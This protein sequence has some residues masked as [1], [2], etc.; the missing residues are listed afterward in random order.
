MGGDS[1]LI[2]R[3]TDAALQDDITLQIIS[4][5]G[6]KLTRGERARIFAKGTNNLEA[7]QKVMQGWEYWYDITLQLHKK[8][9]KK[10]VKSLRRPVDCGYKEIV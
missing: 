1:Q 4:A 9:L 8:T 10:E 3:F 6:A 5:V 2:T 7:Y